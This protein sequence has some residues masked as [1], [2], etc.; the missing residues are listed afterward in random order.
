MDAAP[1]TLSV[2]RR[3]TM[4]DVLPKSRERRA[5]RYLARMGFDLRKSRKRNPCGVDDQGGYMIVDLQTNFVAD[6]SR[7]DLNLDD[8]EAWIA[9]QVDVAA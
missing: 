2:R 6:G 3:K 4:H 7:F 8:V 9:R 1:G 5:R